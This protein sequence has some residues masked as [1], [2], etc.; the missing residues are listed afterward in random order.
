[1]LRYREASPDFFN[2]PQAQDSVEM[3]AGRK[4][5][6]FMNTQGRVGPKGQALGSLTTEGQVNR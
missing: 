1:M 2:P 5:E 3:F 6:Q 4:N